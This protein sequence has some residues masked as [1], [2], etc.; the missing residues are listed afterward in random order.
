MIQ[1]FL[2]K[3]LDSQPVGAQNVG[4]IFKNPAGRFA[5]QLIEEAGFKGKRIGD[6]EVSRKH[7]NFIVNRGGARAEDV[8]TLIFEIQK[9]VE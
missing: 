9:A 7:A 2:Q 1:E 8:R 3:R 4:S 6:A 5:A